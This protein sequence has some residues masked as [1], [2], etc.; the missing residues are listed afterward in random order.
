MI[1]GIDTSTD[2][3][4]I[5]LYEESAVLYERTWKTQQRHT[6]VLAPAVA[7]ALEECTL[8]TNRLNGLAVALGPGS[9]TSL[10]IGLAFIKGLS[11]A[12]H[13][14]VAGISTLDCLAYAQPLNDRPLICTLQIGRRRLAVG[15]YKNE[16][17]QWVQDGSTR[18]LTS[19]ELLNQIN[20]PTLVCG[21][22]NEEDRHILARKW[23]SVILV[24]AANSIRRPA[25]LA[26]LAERRFQAGKEDDPA[27]L[28]P[29][30]LHTTDSILSSSQQVE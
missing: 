25:Y 7:D 24:S 20:T 29:I 16:N 4:G 28:T 18:I 3:L 27:T 5:C 13:L 6:I 14:P 12:Q 2:W 30:Y 10:R 9:F 8:S 15:N 21:E 19:K 26:E 1:L 17:G 23:K 11:F 22:L